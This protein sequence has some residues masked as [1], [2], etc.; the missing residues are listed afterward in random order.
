MTEFSTAT[1]SSETASE[2]P[3]LV[4]IDFSEDSKAALKWACDYSA[5][6]GS[7]LVVLHIVHDHADRPGFYKP[8]KNKQLQPMQEVAQSMMDGFIEEMKSEYPGFDCTDS[9]ELQFVRGL[10]P[11]RIV[12]VS[13]LLDASMI[14]VGS[15]GITGLPHMLLGSV[16]ERVVELAHRPVVVVKSRESTAPGKKEIKRQKK[17]R[18]RDR[19]W[20]KQTL[21]LDPEPERD[22]NG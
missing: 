10:P 7:R 6:S 19:Q 5:M 12:E 4:A 1:L 15:R 8:G 2:S 11:T 3:I 20:L 22:G 9:A 21:G 13:E 18:K 17:L 14:V 16:A